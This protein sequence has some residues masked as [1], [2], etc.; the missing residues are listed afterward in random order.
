MSPSFDIVFSYS[1]DACY[2]VT[3]MPLVKIFYQSN[4]IFASCKH[5]RNRVI[6]RTGH[7]NS[8]KRPSRNTDGHLFEYN[9]VICN[10]TT[11]ILVGVKRRYKDIKTIELIILNIIPT[12]IVF[13][14]F[15]KIVVEIVMDPNHIVG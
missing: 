9:D 2:N 8:R 3:L 6:K 4:G 13:K 5:C 10:E 11:D 14:V 15:F 1:C 7:G 12:C